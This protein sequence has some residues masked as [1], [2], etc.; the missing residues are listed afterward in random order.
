[1][2]NLRTIDI[3]ANKEDFIDITP[4]QEDTYSEEEQDESE[5]Q[6]QHIVDYET[7]EL[8]EVEETAEEELF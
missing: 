7:G 4:R 1:M 2:G 8:I 6:K 5:Q 3:N